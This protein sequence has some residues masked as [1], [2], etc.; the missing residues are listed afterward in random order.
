MA[1]KPPLKHLKRKELL[2]RERFFLML[3]K[4]NNYM[5]PV[6]LGH[7]Y[8]CIVTAIME[9]LRKHKFV[10]LPVLGDLALIRQK[11]RPAWVG[12]AHCVIDGREVLKF[13]PN[14]SLRRQMNARQPIVFL[15]HMPPPP[16]K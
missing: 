8:L 1:W 7:V 12:K 14:E 3:S 10:R 9:D 5:D 15:A 2:D 4:H 16:I 11:A 13:Y 6:A